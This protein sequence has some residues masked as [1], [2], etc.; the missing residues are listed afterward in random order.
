MVR[1][2]WRGFDGNVEDVTQERGM[3]SW[4]AMYFLDVPSR[5]TTCRDFWRLRSLQARCSTRRRLCLEGATVRIGFGSDR[6]GFECK[7]RLRNRFAGQGHT[8]E[9]VSPEDPSRR[10]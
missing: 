10:D 2:L 3:E 8:T 1:L 6:I 7:Q 9:D 4:C 5:S